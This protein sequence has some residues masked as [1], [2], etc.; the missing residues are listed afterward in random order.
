V[1]SGGV[2]LAVGQLRIHEIEKEI[3][4][5]MGQV[6]ESAKPS[7]MKRGRRGSKTGESKEKPRS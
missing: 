1:S 2:N 3:S 7:D 6:T 5:L 4:E